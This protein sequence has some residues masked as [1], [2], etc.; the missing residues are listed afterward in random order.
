MFEFQGGIW[1]F[2]EDKPFAKG[3]NPVAF[4]M[5][6]CVNR[7]L[8]DS[9]HIWSDYLLSSEAKTC[10]YPPTSRGRCDPIPQE[11]ERDN[12]RWWYL[13]IRRKLTSRRYGSRGIQVSRWSPHLENLT[14][15]FRCS[16]ASSHPRHLRSL[17]VL[18]KHTAELGPWFNVGHR[19]LAF[20]VHASC[21]HF[22]TMSPTLESVRK[23]RLP[24][25]R[26]QLLRLGADAFIWQ[27]H[28]RTFGTR[29]M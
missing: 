20:S 19:L 28:E 21:L 13:E 24:I 22:D 25:V 4:Q 8:F 10:S 14:R 6:Q 26:Y 18:G 12:R 17:R 29:I 16:P 27:L 3:F 23:Q 9:L 1:T 2:D 15:T 5:R 11:T 7:K